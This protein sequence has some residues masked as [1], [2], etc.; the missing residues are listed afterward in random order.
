M[1]LPS[2]FAMNVTV[3]NLGGDSLIVAGFD[4]PLEVSLRLK[5]HEATDTFNIYNVLGFTTAPTEEFE[6]GKGE[7]KNIDFVINPRENFDT[8]GKYVFNYYIKASDD[9]ESLESLTLR[10]IDFED[11]FRIGSSEINKE[12]N[13]VTVYIENKED[14]RFND[15][16][17]KLSSPFFELEESLDIA[18]S[19][20]INFTTTLN[21]EDFE[22]LVAGFYTLRANIEADGKEALIEGVIKFEEDGNISNTESK[23][24]LFVRT[25]TI[26]NSNEGNT[27]STIESEISKN[28]LS[29]LFTNFKPN[30]DDKEGF[31]FPTYTWS[32]ELKPGDTQEIVAKTNWF[33]PILIII[34]IVAAVKLFNKYAGKDVLVKKRVSFIRTK[35]GELAIKIKIYLHAQKYVERVS[36]MDKLPKF[37]NIHPRFGVEE[38]I[39][40]DEQNKRVEWGFEKLEAGETRILT[41]ISFSKLGVMGRFALPKTTVI[42]EKE[43]KVKESKSNKT[44][45]VAEHKKGE[46]KEE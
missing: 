23:K 31:F 15:V 28:I 24:G 21:D 17:V 9:E 32:S 5:N 37:L 10:I 35:N 46:K 11:V 2:I 40:V 1:V 43:G 19:E 20:S 39:R 6:I 8:R 22:E 14:F 16:L 36:V 45:F 27:I 44:F 30:P 7:T 12:T 34:L 26:K 29:G 18:P 33:Y 41:Y 25:T 42:Y 38:P 4:N 13:E 3:E